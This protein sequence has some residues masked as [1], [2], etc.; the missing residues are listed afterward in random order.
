MEF[1]LVLFKVFVCLISL[2][3]LSY[4]NLN[5]CI[6]IKDQEKERLKV[7]SYWNLNGINIT[8]YEKLDNLKYYHIGI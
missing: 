3:V 1:K 2:K 6:Y 5:G 4:W 7:L 8:N